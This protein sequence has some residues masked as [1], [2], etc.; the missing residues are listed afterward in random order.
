VVTCPAPQRRA[1]ARA[2]AQALRFRAPVSDARTL[3]V[4]ATDDDLRAVASAMAQAQ[5]LSTCSCGGASG[6]TSSPPG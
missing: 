4:M 3:F 2:L 6:F 5:Y 1:A